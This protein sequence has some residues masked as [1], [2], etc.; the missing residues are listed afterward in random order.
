ML[1]PRYSVPLTPEQLEARKSMPTDS[2]GFIVGLPWLADKAVKV[3]EPQ[4][5]EWCASH[6]KHLWPDWCERWADVKRQRGLA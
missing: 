6:P 5:R 1:R 3:L 4:W 2:H